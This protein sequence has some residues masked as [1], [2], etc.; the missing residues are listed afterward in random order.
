MPQ[1]YHDRKENEF[2]F[3]K[4]GSMTVLEYERRF[5][6]LSRYARHLVDHEWKKAKHFEKGLHPEISGILARYGTMTYAAVFTRAQ[7]IAS[8]LNLVQRPKPNILVRR[9]RS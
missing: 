8:R 3:L 5:S 9:L 1:S 7:E 6:Q 2:L 4:Q